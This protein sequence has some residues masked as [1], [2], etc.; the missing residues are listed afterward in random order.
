MNTKASAQKSSQTHSTLNTPLNTID[1]ETRHLL[2]EVALDQELASHKVPSVKTVLV[3]LSSKGLAYDIEAL[4]QKIYHTYPDAVVF[5]Q[6]TSGEPIGAKCPNQVDLLIDFTGPR[7][8]QP[9]FYSRKLRKMARVTVGRN[10]GFF[11]MG[12]YDRIVNEFDPD[13]KFPD[14]MLDRERFIQRQVLH[15]AGVPTKAIGHV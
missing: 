6:A 15:L 3:V 7:Q 14:D 2:T 5:F 13:F 1:T 9:W 8:K 12:L 11:R 10:A 4:R